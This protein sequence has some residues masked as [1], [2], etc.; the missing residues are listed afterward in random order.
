M[1]APPFGIRSAVAALAIAGALF[2]SAGCDGAAEE[3]ERLAGQ[4]EQ[5]HEERQ[6]LMR[7]LSDANAEIAGL[8]AQ[9]RDLSSANENLG[10]EKELLAREATRLKERVRTLNEQLEDLARRSAEAVQEAPDED[11]PPTHPELQGAVERLDALSQAL[12]ER[13]DLDVALSVALAAEELGAASSELYYR[14]A[15]CKASAGDHAGAA[16]WYARAGADEDSG[17]ADLRL[18]ILTNWGVALAEIGDSQG[19]AQRYRQ[20]LQID[21]GYAPA[22]FNLGLIYEQDPQ[23]DVEAIAAFRS[24]IIHGGARGLSARRHIAR[25]QASQGE[26]AAEGPPE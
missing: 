4:L 9:V 23:R 11:A 16:E 1:T 7:E 24:H 14:I 6:G 17:D 25:L 8:N 13:G 10:V 3:A 22:W 15:F 18:K 12:F 26:E 19:A 5:A 21:D 20:A 2:S